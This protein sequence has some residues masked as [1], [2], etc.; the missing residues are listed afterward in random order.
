MPSNRS[1]HGF[2]QADDE[3]RWVT[4]EPGIPISQLIRG[5]VHAGGTEAVLDFR[6]PALR[7]ASYPELRDIDEQIEGRGI[8]LMDFARVLTWAMSWE[9]EQPAGGRRG[10]SARGRGKCH[11]AHLALA[12]LRQG[13]PVERSIYAGV[14]KVLAMPASLIRETAAGIMVNRW[15]RKRDVLPAL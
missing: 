15:P 5:E 8:D 3:E 7:A 13:Q 12:R 10:H 1:T 4:V 6:D 9:W 2:T 14:K 11:Q